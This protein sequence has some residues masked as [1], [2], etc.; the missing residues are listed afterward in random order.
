VPDANPPPAVLPVMR[1]TNV[2]TK[3]PFTSAKSAQP[4]DLVS[5]AG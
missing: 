5:T 1:F 2:V 3:Q 4:A